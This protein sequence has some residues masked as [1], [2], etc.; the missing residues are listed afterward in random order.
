[1]MQLVQNTLQSIQKGRTM[2]IVT[3]VRNR[4]PF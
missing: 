3:H 1:M 4:P 2:I